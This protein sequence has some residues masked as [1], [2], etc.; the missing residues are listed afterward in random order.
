MRR[1]TRL[2]RLFTRRERQLPAAPRLSKYILHPA[3]HRREGIAH[4]KRGRLPRRPVARP[5]H[6]VALQCRRENDE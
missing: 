2:S 4:L 1:G 6:S 5:G 3:V